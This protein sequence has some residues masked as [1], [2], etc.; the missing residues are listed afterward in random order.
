MYQ[1]QV[2]HHGVSPHVITAQ[3][4]RCAVRTST[5]WLSGEGRAAL[6]HRTSAAMPG[7]AKWCN[8]W[9]SQQAQCMACTDCTDSGCFRPAA[10]PDGFDGSPNAGLDAAYGNI[11]ATTPGTIEL[12]G[13]GRGYIIK[14]HT[15]G[16]QY[17]LFNMLGK[18]LH[19]TVDVSKV[20][21][22]CNAALYFVAMRAGNSPDN[23]CDIQTTP[24]CTELDA[25]E[26]NRGAIQAT[27]HTQLGKGGDGTCKC[28]APT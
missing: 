1:R 17:K 19:F 15:K 8:K 4:R 16:R 13:N 2:A 7:C 23:Y 26:A 21:C 20:P 25:Y 22:G 24:S 3:C 11:E 6:Q 27:V 5:V 14:D 9:T 10:F 12:S 18:T 28:A